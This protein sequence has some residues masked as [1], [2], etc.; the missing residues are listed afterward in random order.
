MQVMQGLFELYEDGL[1]QGSSTIL[2]EETTENKEK[3]QRASN[4][5]D[6]EM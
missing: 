2:L 1:F 5:A 3:L 4:A 6:I